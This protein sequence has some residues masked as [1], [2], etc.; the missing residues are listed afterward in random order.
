MARAPATTDPLQGRPFAKMSGGGNDFVVFDNRDGWFPKDRA[1]ELVAR[2][3]R[4]GLGVG[5][6]AVLLLEDDAAADARMAYFN[7]D[8]GE[9]PMCGNG[10]LCIARYARLVGAVRDDTLRL[11]TGSGTF[12]ARVPDPAGTEVTL[13]LVPPR[14]LALRYAELEKPPCRR[15]GFVDTSTPHV[16]VL[17]D[18]VE[19]FDVRGEGPRFRRDPRWDPPGANAN[20]VSVLD[21][22]TVRMRTYERGVEDETLSCGTGATAS[23]I[24]TCLWGLTE[25]PVTVRTS[26][27]FPLIVEFTR[28]PDA[29]SLPADPRL[30]GDARVVFR[31]TLDEV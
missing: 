20:F 8:G 21:R 22:H 31:G 14:D 28:P 4:R 13:W 10:A 9:A 27:G 18:D 2:I 1:R 26:G 3:C 29:A 6:D 23:A 15:V 30:T 12:H 7:A 5:V 24:L 19:S 16:V 25:P 17:V 11:A